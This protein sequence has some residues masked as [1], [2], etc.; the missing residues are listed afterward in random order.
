MK[1][2]IIAAGMGNRLFHLTQDTPKCLLK[3]NGKPIIEH[4]LDI[5]KSLGIT[6]ITIVKGFLKDQINYPGTKSYINSDY[7]NNNILAS[8]MY[9]ESEINDD[10][11]IS[12]SDIIYEKEVVEKLLNATA[13]IATVVD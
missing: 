1:A 11:L 3:I 12:Y 7:K 13:D 5:F 10:V 4:Q 6:D 8:L 9:A 2:I